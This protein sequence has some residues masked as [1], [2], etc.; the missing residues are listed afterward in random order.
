MGHSG[1][2]LSAAGA[3][4][5]ARSPIHHCRAIGYAAILLPRG[6]GGVCAPDRPIARLTAFF[7]AIVHAAAAQ[8]RAGRLVESEAA[9]F[10]VAIKAVL[11]G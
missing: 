7:F 5:L 4:D 1:S 6:P 10:I 8:V 11:A 2:S 3:Q 9:T